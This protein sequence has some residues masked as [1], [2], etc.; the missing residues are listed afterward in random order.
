MFAILEDTDDRLAMRLGSRNGWN[1]ATFTMDKRTG[2]LT[3]ERKTM[4]VSRR[5]IDVAFADV[6]RVDAVT[7]K[8][9]G[10]VQH[11]IIVGL[12]SGKRRWCA[13]DEPESN[14]KAVDRMR[15]FMALQP[16]DAKKSSPLSPVYRWTLAGI[17]VAG[18]IVAVASGFGKV[19]RYFILP[20][21]DEQPVLETLGDLVAPGKGGTV[22]FSEFRTVSKAHD[23]NLC[24]ATARMGADVAI[25]NYATEWN[26]W[27]AAVRSYG[28]KT[29]EGVSDEMAANVKS[30]SDAI[31]A[32]ASGSDTTGAVPPPA[33]PDTAHGLDRLLD[34]SDI[35][36][37]RLKDS[38]LA[39]LITWFNAGHAVGAVYVLAGTGYHEFQDVPQEPV[40][41]ARIDKNIAAQAPVI[42]RYLDFEI[43]IL[44]LIA[45]LELK[46]TAAQ[47]KA[48][49]KET[50]DLLAPFR[51]TLLS[52]F[53]TSLYDILVEGVTDDW[54]AD[55]LATIEKRLDTARIFLTQSQML[56]LHDHIVEA[57]S[58]SGSE[59]IRKRLG[60]LEG[61]VL[62][63]T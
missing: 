42:G 34:T 11:S 43:D 9:K 30:A 61:K 53:E 35:V 2:R 48:E 5:T 50:T 12:R 21:C 26:G 16:I 20:D 29:Y 25:I 24:Q 40:V 4:F 33:D 45:T 15:A 22:N 1:V 51:A 13:A 32:K 47:G 27:T 14:F 60:A 44:S 56:E 7:T 58:K 19:S 18:V 10:T 57:G 46:T 36:P 17:T 6:A 59:S 23:R 49:P 63:G 52:A 39:K 37:A 38:D 62:S 54:R 31:L 8:V 41:Q 55:R 3:I 28:G